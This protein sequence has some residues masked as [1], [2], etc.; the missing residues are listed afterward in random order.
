MHKDK[1]Q[2]RDSLL[3]VGSAQTCHP[4]PCKD[5]KHKEYQAKHIFEQ[6]KHHKS[7]QQRA[8]TVTEA[9]DGYTNHIDTIKGW[10]MVTERNTKRS[11]QGRQLEKIKEIQDQVQWMPTI[12]DKWAM[13]YF[14]TL[15]GYSAKSYT[16]YYRHGR[17]YLHLSGLAYR[18]VRSVGAPTAEGMMRTRIATT[19]C[20]PVQLAKSTIMQNASANV[21]GDQIQPWICGAVPR[22]KPP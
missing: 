4:C 17:T 9:M 2:K 8:A 14:E 11:S 16:P 18:R 19:T 1:A 5:H 7:E 20:W 22:A 10:R 15:A 12:I 3:R 6:N 13:P 21:D